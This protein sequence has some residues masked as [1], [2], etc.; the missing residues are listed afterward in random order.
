MTAQPSSFLRKAFTKWMAREKPCISHAVRLRACIFK[1]D[2]IGD[3]VLALSAIRELT[4]HYGESNCALIVY[5]PIVELAKNE[6][7][8]AT[9]IGLRCPSGGLKSA[10]AVFFNEADRFRHYQF[11]NLIC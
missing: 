10:L 5:R 8:A 1:L 6:F 2:R 9:I 11:E 3:F 4:R 7:P